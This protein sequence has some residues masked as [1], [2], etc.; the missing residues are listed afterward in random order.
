MQTRGRAKA[1]TVPSSGNPV[2]PPLPPLEGSG[3]RPP[4]MANEGDLGL[5]SLLGEGAVSDVGGK[6]TSESA[7]SG[8]GDVMVVAAQAPIPEVEVIASDG[9]IVAGS[10]VPSSMATGNTR[11]PDTYAQAPIAST[12]GSALSS[13]RGNEP[14]QLPSLH[15]SGEARIPTIYCTASLTDCDSTCCNSQCLTVG[16]IDDEVPNLFHCL[17]LKTHFPSDYPL[18]RYGIT[19]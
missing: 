15:P 4:S 3:S 11:L 18:Y 17:I 5:V 1:Q 13:G 10:A 19:C 7:T 2:T 12:Q 6:C 14:V 8:L 9:Q 16:G